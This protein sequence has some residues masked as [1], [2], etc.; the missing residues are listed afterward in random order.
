MEINI[1]EMGSS[2]HKNTK[3]EFNAEEDEEFF[4]IKHEDSHKIQ[5]IVPADK[6]P[7]KPEVKY[8]LDKQGIDT[9]SNRYYLGQASSTKFGQ[10]N[11]GPS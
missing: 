1:P 8:T 10:E 3:I 4:H 11:N 2:H 7:D 9:S 5:M 6:K